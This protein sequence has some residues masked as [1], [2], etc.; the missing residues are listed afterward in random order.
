MNEADLSDVCSA[1]RKIGEAITPGSAMAGYDE[2]GGTV[3]SL[4]EAAMG[5]TA[6]LCKIAEAI[7]RLASAVEDSNLKGSG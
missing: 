4:T 2:A 1:L 6:G 7:D 3:T 5:I